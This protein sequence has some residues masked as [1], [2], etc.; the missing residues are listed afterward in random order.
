M[1]HL[2]ETNIKLQLVNAGDNTLQNFSENDVWFLKLPYYIEESHIPD[3]NNI[4]KEL[5]LFI[6]KSNKNATIAIL[7]SPIFAAHF[8]SELTPLGHFK[9]WIGV[10]LNNPISTEFSLKQHHA[11]LIIITRYSITLQHTKTRIGYTFCPICDKTTKDYGGKK[12]LYNDYG[13]L[14]SDVWRDI[15]IDYSK[16]IDIIKERLQD[17]FAIEHYK[18]LNYIDLTKIY[19][20]IKSNIYV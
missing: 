13:T 17:L 18:Y 1:A 5:N 8:L 6:E 11:A 16:D 20:P 4:T 3:I 2:S 19:S 12:H 14:M 9:L 10:K 7:T 15:E